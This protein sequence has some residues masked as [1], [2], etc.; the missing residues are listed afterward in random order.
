MDIIQ[1]TKSYER[2]LAAHIAVDKTDLRQK[3]LNMASS[4]FIFL[5][6]TFYRWAQTW[7]EVCGDLDNAPEVLSVGDLHIENFG[8]WRDADGRLI[9][10]I[11][12]LDEVYPLPYS[13]DLIRLATSVRLANLQTISLSA[14]CE[15]ILEGYTKGYT[16]GGRPFVLEEKHRK[17]R[18]MATNVLRDPTRYWE[19]LDALKTLK[20]KAPRAAIE[21]IER[22]MPAP[23]IR[24]RLVHRQAGEGSLGRQR[25]L[26]LADW[27]GG[28]IAREAKALLPSACV[29]A[30]GGTSKDIL[31]QTLLDRAV[32]C[33][34]PFFEAKGGWITRRLAPDCSRIELPSL[35]AASDERVVLKAM[36]RETANM[37]LGTPDA[38]KAVLRDLKKR[39]DGWLCEAA[40]K[41]TEAVVHDWKDWRNSVRSA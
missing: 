27:K 41:M 32:R 11:N 20:E 28:K 2:W 33:K 19:K 17:L 8:S 24:C 5:R 3:H 35:H 1:A 16:K 21:A 9:W 39:P 23:R 25:F 31:Y 38:S 15:A 22:L 37:H 30:C 14:A 34:D 40:E 26:A 4:P 6:A 29:W 36:G 13:N 10:G 12:D 7:A 18:R